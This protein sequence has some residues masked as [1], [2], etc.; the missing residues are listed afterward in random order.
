MGDKP[1][2]RRAILF[3]A[4]AATGT[5]AIGLSVN[6]LAAHDRSTPDGMDGAPPV[7]TTTVDKVDLSDTQTFPAT[8]GYGALRTVKGAG[9]GIVTRLPRP[10]DVV[11]RGKPLYWVND[12]PVP[13]FYGDTPLFRRLDNTAPHGN[14]VSMVSENLAALGYQ[15]GKIHDT[16]TTT[17]ST[18]VKKWQQDTGLAGTGVLDAGQVLVFA[19]P[20]RVS[21]VTAQP[22][23]A[24][25]GDLLS[26][27]STAKRVTV[28]MDPTEV[29]LINTGA[30]V[31]IM[32]PTGK[33]TPGK[34]TTISQTV[35]GGGPDDPSGQTAKPQ[36]TVTV[37]AV[38]A[39]D[40]ANLDA[41]A[42]QVRM[43]TQTRP[44]V[45]AVPVG[46]LL[47]LRSGGYA[48]QLPDGRL[49][50]ARTGMFAKGMVEVSG[51]GIVAGLRVVTT[52]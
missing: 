10:G 31:T 8:L 4:V 30:D 37:T 32:L 20:V 12:V 7:R 41:A 13:V 35:T 19:E 15:V 2:R 16:Y 38:T 44:G 51:D 42:V 18:A 14:D 29:T 34:V 48:V 26:V 43:T 5:V 3:G 6:V 1:V 52:S 45:L 28:P 21:A 24:A 27:T 9:T 25:A 50:A 46:A 23:D 40:V 47:A 33:E 36:L 49:L 11:A 39:A 22:G 17:L